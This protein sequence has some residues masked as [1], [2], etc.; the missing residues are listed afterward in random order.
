[1]VATCAS[2][3]ANNIFPETMLFF[4]FFCIRFLGVVEGHIRRY[5][6]HFVVVC[7]NC[8]RFAAIMSSWCSC[9]STIL[10]LWL[11]LVMMSWS[12]STSFLQLFESILNRMEQGLNNLLLDF[13]VGVVN[14]LPSFS[15]VQQHPVIYTIILFALTFQYLVE[16]LSQKVIIWSFFKP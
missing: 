10:M 13:I 1:M 6:R 16:K 8:T 2:Y 11:G 3:K 5:R 12:S 15:F 7:L 14:Y 9:S 4:S